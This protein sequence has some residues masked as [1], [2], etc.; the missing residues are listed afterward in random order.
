MS[1]DVT[2]LVVRILFVLL[3][4]LFLA[5]LLVLLKRDLRRAGVRGR[6]RLV[7]LEAPDGAPAAGTAFELLSG[8]RLGRSDPAEVILDDSYVSAAHAR[9]TSRNG[10]WYV[11]DLGS[12]NGTLLNGSRVCR[13]QP[14][15]P[16]DTLQLGRTTLQFDT[17]EP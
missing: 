16:G 7:V 5:Q 13:R 14:V 15:R 17:V 3:L 1:P 11:E 9:L 10:T 4:Y 6:A 12:T 8:D 2:L